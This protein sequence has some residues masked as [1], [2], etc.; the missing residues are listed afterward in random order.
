MQT[1]SSRI[2]ILDNSNLPAQSVE[3]LNSVAKQLGFVPNVLRLLAASP[4]VLKSF[5]GL[6]A[7]LSGTLDLN[8]RNAIALAVSESNSC[9]YCVSAHAHF[10]SKGANC[11]KDEI[12]R[13]RVGESIDPKR[14]AAAAFGVSVIKRHGNVSNADLEK[15]REAGYSDSE[16]LEIIALAVQFSFTNF[17]NNVAQTEI[18]FPI[19]D[20]PAG[21]TEELVA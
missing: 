9:H 4:A 18:D 10:A 3:I 21:M 7:G 13:N 12:S 20:A 16:I 6:Q 15:I 8:T 17:M 2:K 19:V 14:A 5:L 11:S 1:T